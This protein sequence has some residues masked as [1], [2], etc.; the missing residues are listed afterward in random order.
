MRMPGRVANGAINFDNMAA[1][2]CISIKTKPGEERKIF[3][4][5]QMSL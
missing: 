3:L 5:W 4:P 1:A 2:F